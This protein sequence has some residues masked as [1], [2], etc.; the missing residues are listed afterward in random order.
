MITVILQYLA[1]KRSFCGVFM[2]FTPQYLSSSITFHNGG[3]QCQK[4]ASIAKMDLFFMTFSVFLSLCLLFEARTMNTRWLNPQF[5]A[6]Q[7]QILILSIRLWFGCK[8]LVFCGNNG[9]LMDSIKM[10]ADKLVEN[11]PN[12]LKSICPIC[13][14]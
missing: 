1:K 3:Q 13:L 10:V 14:P 9:W 7:I 6:A 4:L 12:T 11:A 2:T 5:F 8:G